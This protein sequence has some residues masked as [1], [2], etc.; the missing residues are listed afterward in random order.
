M[1]RR[2]R[3]MIL[4]T[5]RGRDITEG[6]ACGLTHPGAQKKKPQKALRKSIY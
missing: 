2:Y 3:D 5:Y 4:T 1:D 6:L